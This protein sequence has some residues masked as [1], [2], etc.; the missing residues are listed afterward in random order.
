MIYLFKVSVHKGILECI[1]NSLTVF[2]GNKTKRYNQVMKI[3]VV[4]IKN[5]QQKKINIVCATFL[6]TSVI[7]QNLG[8]SFLKLSTPNFRKG[9]RSD[10]TTLTNL[11]I[12]N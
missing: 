5:R 2:Q 6:K 12:E 3:K 8:K 10:S 1:R 9:L 4:F 11:P 7:Y